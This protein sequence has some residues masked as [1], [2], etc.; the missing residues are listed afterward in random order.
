M[1]KAAQYCGFW[2]LIFGLVSALLL[3]IFGNGLVGLMTNITEVRASAR[4]FLPWVI[5]LPLAGVAAFLY[6][7][8]YIGA[9]AAKTLRNA[10]LLSAVV[11]LLTLGLSH[12][13][14]MFNNHTLWLAMI[15]F[16]LCRGGLLAWGYPR[17]SQAL[18]GRA[19]NT[20]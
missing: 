8:I 12:Q 15:L 9:G 2:A 10:M 14:G 19:E 7:G 20:N 4:D 13:F 1:H 16:M 18:F 5:G 6:D 3:F 11:Y 17:L